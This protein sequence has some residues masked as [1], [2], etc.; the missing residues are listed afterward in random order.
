M[1]RNPTGTK[2]AKEFTDFT[3]P[4][5]CNKSYRLLT[6]EIDTKDFYLQ[7][8]AE[9]PSKDPDYLYIVQAIRE[10]LGTKEIKDDSEAKQMDG[11]WE[12]MGILDTE[13][14]AGHQ[15]WQ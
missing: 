7:Q 6:Y 4:T 12:L 10:R 9:G 2:E 14:Q 11:Q 5:I 8:V 15:E 3:S 13:G 1:S